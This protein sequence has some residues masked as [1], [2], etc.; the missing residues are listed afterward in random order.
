MTTRRA[1]FIVIF[2]VRVVS[3]DAIYCILFSVP[4]PAFAVVR[5]LEE[6][7]LFSEVWVIFVIVSIVMLG[8]RIRVIRVVEKTFSARHG[9]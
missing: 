1:G 9:S 3:K 2:I 5:V 6:F 4:A 8:R 7:S